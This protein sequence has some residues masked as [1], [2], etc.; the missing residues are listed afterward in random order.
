MDDLQ[1]KGTS[2]S[3]KLVMYCKPDPSGINL[4]AS[5]G[6]VDVISQSDNFLLPCPALVFPSDP[7][8]ASLNCDRQSSRLHLLSVSYTL[9]SYWLKTST[10]VSKTTTMAITRRPAPSSVV[11]AVYPVTLILGSLFSVISP[12]ARATRG[13]STPV[14]G[15]SGPLAPSLA[16]DLHLS[17]SPANY[18][19]R[20]NNVFNL[21]FVK[22]GWVWLTVAFA[23]LLLFQPIYNSSSP[24]SQSQQQARFRRSLQALLRYTIATIVWYFM[25]QWFFGPPIIDRGFVIT[26]GKCEYVLEK[27]GKVTSDTS[28]AGRLET[29]FSAA[30]CKAAG[31]AWRGGYDISGHVFMLVLMTAIL[32]FE[33]VGAGA[34]GTFPSARAE[35]DGPRERKASEPDSV[36][37]S[38][39]ENASSVA[40]TW[41]I[42]LVWGV[43]I[44]GWWMLFMTAI[45]FHT[46]LEKVCSR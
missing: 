9:Q 37:G 41:S 44:L 4:R 7:Q 30:A 12:T 36:L 27:A 24:S 6:A 29:L 8:F 45:W 13:S 3:D 16:A 19:A 17:E 10:P 1:L 35:S 2:N 33:A 20:K 22:I 18:F 39:Q 28:T 43:V 31:G 46:W 5:A 11:L 26:G 34:V 32:A 40:R 25:T 38:G 42:R 21:Y 14:S 15:P 23:S